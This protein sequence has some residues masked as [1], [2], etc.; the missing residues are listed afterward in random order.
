MIHASQKS[1]KASA[2][3]D[4]AIMIALTRRRLA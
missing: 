1:P 4:S 3:A 2:A